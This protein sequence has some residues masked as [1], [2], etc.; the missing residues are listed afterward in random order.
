[1]EH[2]L[3]VSTLD[4]R[5]TAFNKKTGEKIW[6]ID[7]YKGT[8]INVK[9][10]SNPFLEENGIFIPEVASGIGRL[11]YYS[12]DGISQTKIPLKEIINDHSVF[13]DDL[14]V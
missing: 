9:G 12:K 1:M 5:L 6:D 3:V 7:D 2:L 10:F 8:M 14:N 13:V 11:Y 4:G